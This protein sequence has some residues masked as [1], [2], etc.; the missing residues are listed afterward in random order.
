M[1][2][3]GLI[4]VSATM[5]ASSAFASFDMLVIPNASGDR[6]DRYDPVNRVFLGSMFMNG[7]NKVSANSS[8]PNGFYS[9][10]GGQTLMNNYTGERISNPS[11]SSAHLQLGLSGGLNSQ[12]STGVINFGSLNS[13][14]ILTFSASFAAPVGNFIAGSTAV[15]STQWLVTTTSATGL[16]AYLVNSTGTIA[17]S[18][19]NLVPIAGLTSTGVG[20]SAT[21]T[22]GTTRYAAIPYRDNSGDHRLL[23][24]AIGSSSVTF[25]SNQ[26]LSGFSTGNASTTLCAVAGHTGFFLVGADTPGTGATRITEFDSAPAFGVMNSYTTT[27]ISAQSTNNQWRMSNIVA[28]EPGSMVAL[29]L[30][31]VAML[32]RRRKALA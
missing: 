8:S 6:Y 19:L 3:R 12:T 13:A 9:Y 27:S 22:R 15:N 29:G 17:A 7:A 31:M 10:A 25:S 24:V 11:F 20:Q 4:V 23:A 21:F 16:N 30:G 14:N 26:S 1:F 2:I 32:K 28:P 5:L 18:A